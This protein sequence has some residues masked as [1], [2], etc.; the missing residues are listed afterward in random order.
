[1]GM[2]Y[3]LNHQLAATG[4]LPLIDFICSYGGKVIIIRRT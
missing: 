3:V 2:I 4:Y 1:M